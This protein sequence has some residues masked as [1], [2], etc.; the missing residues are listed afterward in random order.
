MMVSKRYV[1]GLILFAFFFAG[2]DMFQQMNL[3][4][5]QELSAQMEQRI[6]QAIKNKD[7]STLK[8]I[9]KSATPSIIKAVLDIANDEYKSRSVTSSSFACNLI[10]DLGAIR[11]SRATPALTYLLGNVKYRTFHPS[12]ARALAQLGDRSAVD[13]LKKA[14]EREMGYIA[15]GDGKGPDYGW[16]LAGNF[17]YQVASETGNALKRFGVYVKIPGK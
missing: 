10:H 8:S 16:G 6:T 17:S 11:D 9:G 3:V 13:S 4:P 2:C 1:F 14:Y 12:V 5:K 15:K 7:H